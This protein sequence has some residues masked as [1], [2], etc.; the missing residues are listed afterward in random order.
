MAVESATG[1]ELPGSDAVLDA[2]SLS[3]P[4]VRLT[5]PPAGT[6]SA[7]TTKAAVQCKCPSRG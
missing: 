7:A 1:E 4:M 3:A 5:M 2:A 6:P